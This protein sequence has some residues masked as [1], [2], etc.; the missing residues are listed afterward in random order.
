MT[1]Y[2]LFAFAQPQ[3]AFVRLY[4]EGTASF[5]RVLVTLVGGLDMSGRV[6][7][8]FGVGLTGAL[9]AFNAGRERRARRGGSAWSRR[10]PGRTRI[11]RFRSSPAPASCRAAPRRFRPV[12]TV[13]STDHRTTT[14]AILRLPS[15]AYPAGAVPV[16]GGYYYLNGQYYD[17]NGNVVSGVPTVP[18]P[19]GAYPG[20]AYGGLCG[21]AGS[22]GVHGGRADRWL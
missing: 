13:A 12:S 20:Y 18:F 17:A 21:Y 6:H 8:W 5:A 10:S 7:R 19:V 3:T 15:A 9:F 1:R 2:T 14:V 4:C 16:N 11:A 22:C